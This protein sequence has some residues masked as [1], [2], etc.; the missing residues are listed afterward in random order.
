MKSVVARAGRNKDVEEIEEELKRKK[1]QEQRHAEEE[2]EQLQ[3][4]LKIPAMLG[5]DNIERMRNQKRE[6]DNLRDDIDK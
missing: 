5:A 6:L 1:R 3:Q 4:F 2:R